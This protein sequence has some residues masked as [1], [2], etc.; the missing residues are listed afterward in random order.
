MR[1]FLAG[2]LAE[3]NSYVPIPTGLGAFEAEGIR[4]GPAS[5]ID[6][7]GYLGAIESVYSA[8]HSRGWEVCEGLFAAAVPLG[9][10]R[11]PVYEQLRDELLEDLRAAMPVNALML[12][13]HGAMTAEDCLDCEGD[14]I[15]RARSIV[16]PDVP[17]GVELDLHANVTQRMTRQAT[18][19]VAYKAYPHTDI[20][21]RAAEV[22]RLTLDTAEGRIH[23]VTAIWDCR[24]AGSWPTTREPLKSFVRDMQALEG[25]NG[26]LSVSHAHGYEFGDVPECGARIW[27]ITDGDAELATRVASDLGRRVWA[28]RHEL[29]QP[30]LDMQTAM[31]RLAD[32]PP[33]SGMGPIVVA[34]TADNP[35]GGARGDSSFALQALL[36]EGVRNVA[37][38]GLWDPGAVQ[39][40]FEAGLGSTLQLRV[41][42]KSGP[43]SGSP[44]DLRVTVRALAED[45]GQTAF[46]SR[47]SLGPAAWVSTAEDVDLVLISRCQQVI[48]TDLFTGLGIDLS[49]KHGVVVKSMQHFLAAFAPLAR[50]VLYA[51]SPGLLTADFAALPFRHRDPNFWPRVADPWSDAGPCVPYVNP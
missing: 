19:M 48:G 21:E 29:T 51:D 44:I 24:M 13:L 4:R 9:P 32:L 50:E 46:G 2:L 31:R 42:G 20:E 45:H 3:N 8:A 39:L 38:G 27:A 14:L 18:L 5:G 28:M 26:V 6:P 37:I 34:D 1:L 11:Q 12:V 49:S 23:P 16:G 30:P 40:C 10:I 33:S 47:I 43:T 15:E 7:G 36:V 41:A 17:I 25:R 35:G 22:V